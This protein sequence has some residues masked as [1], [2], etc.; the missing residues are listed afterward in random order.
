[1]NFGLSWDISSI[2][3]WDR[4]SDIDR[5][6]IFSE[7]HNGTLVSG[8]VFIRYNEVIVGFTGT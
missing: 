2:V 3:S 5:Q 1:M 7:G 4:Q 8:P 6:K